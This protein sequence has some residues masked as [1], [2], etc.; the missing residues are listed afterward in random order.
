MKKKPTPIEPDAYKELVISSSRTIA[1]SARF[2][3]TVLRACALSMEAD[4][5]SFEGRAAQLASAEDLELVMI[6]AREAR[7]AAD[8]AIDQVKALMRPLAAAS[9]G[10]GVTAAEITKACRMQKN[11]VRAITRHMP[12]GWTVLRQWEAGP[13]LQQSPHKIMEAYCPR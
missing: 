2:D 12:P 11:P 5:A 10:P 7:R 9:P 6:R 4:A 8:A 1:R 3:A 13:Q